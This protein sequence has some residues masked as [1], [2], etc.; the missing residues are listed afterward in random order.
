MKSD[1]F[2]LP[3]SAARLR[4][5]IAFFGRRIS[6]DLVLLSAAQASFFLTTSAVPFLSLFMALTAFLLPGGLSRSPLPAFFPDGSGELLRLLENETADPAD[7]LRYYS[8]DD[9]RRCGVVGIE[10]KSN[11]TVDRTEER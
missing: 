11:G 1:I 5:Q 2:S 6:D 4:V 7:M 3:R 10:I 8:E 9:I